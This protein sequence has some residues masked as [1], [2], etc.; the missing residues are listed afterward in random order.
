VSQPAA[1]PRLRVARWE[2]GEAHV[3]Y[4]ATGKLAATAIGHVIATRTDPPL[5]IVPSIGYGELRMDVL[6]RPAGMLVAV[7]VPDDLPVTAPRHIEVLQL[8]AQGEAPRF[9]LPT[10]NVSRP[11][12]AEGAEDSVWLGYLAPDGVHI[13]ELRC[14]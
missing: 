10:A 12:L 4:T 14:R 2:G 7:E 3:L 8:D 5:P 9:K 1:P 11:A 13:A 6:T